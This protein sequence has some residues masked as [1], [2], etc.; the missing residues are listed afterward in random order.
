A[1]GVLSSAFLALPIV[2][3]SYLALT[4]V[5]LRGYGFNPSGPIH[6]GDAF[7]GQRF[8]SEAT[9]VEHGIGY[10]GQFFYYLA[11]DPFLH[12]D[13][14]ESFIDRPAYRYG[15]I[16]YPALCWAASLGRPEAVPWAMLGVNLVA[17]VLGTLAAGDLLRSMG[18]NRLL[19]LAFAFSPAVLLGSIADLAD[20]VALALVVAAFALH[21]RRRHGAAG[22]ALAFSS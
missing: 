3:L 7:A 6:I 22:L 12:S 10:D 1:L 16:L 19:A 11:L 14:P 13:D 5:L 9:H 18:A 17:V 4:V 21:L 20:P 15:R 2:L 8:W